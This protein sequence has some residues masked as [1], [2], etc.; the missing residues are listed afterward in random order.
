[1]CHLLPKAY[2]L[3]DAAIFRVVEAGVGNLKAGDWR[4]NRRNHRREA[5]RTD[6]LRVAETPDMGGNQVGLCDAPD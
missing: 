4:L 1:M 2:A 3:G 5:R 6:R